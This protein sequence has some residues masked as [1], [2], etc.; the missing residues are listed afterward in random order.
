MIRITEEPQLILMLKGPEILPFSNLV[1]NVL[2][3]Y[4]HR[5]QE[6]MRDDPLYIHR[7]G[8]SHPHLNLIKTTMVLCLI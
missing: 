1:E 4:E 3:L 2:V 6:Q 7:Y 5:R 8:K